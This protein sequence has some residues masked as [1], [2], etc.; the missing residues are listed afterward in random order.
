M[1]NYNTENKM[2][3]NKF[4][5]EEDELK[6]EIEYYRSK[7]KIVIVLVIMLFTVVRKINNKTFYFC[8]SL[9]PGFIFNLIF[10]PNTSFLLLFTHFLFWYFLNE[11][12]FNQEEMD[13]VNCDIDTL[14]RSLKNF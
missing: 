6:E 4:N 10:F 8:I 7:S 3:E 2:N 13:K 14:I 9:F 11:K 12:L 5:N 1:R